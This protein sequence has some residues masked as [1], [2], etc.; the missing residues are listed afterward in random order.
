MTG[1]PIDP[2]HGAAMRIWHQSFTDLER[3][4]GYAGMLAERGRHVCSAGTVVDLHGV[5]PDTYPDGVAPVDVGGYRW[6]TEMIALQVVENCVRAEREGYDAV[7]ISCF[8]DPGLELARSLVDIP[9]VSSLETSLLMSCTI[10]RRPGLLT[11]DGAMVR[12]VERLVADY[13]FQGRLAGIDHLD[14]PLT[15]FDL[16]AGFGGSAALTER[17]RA[18]A[19]RLIARGAD[20]LIPAEGVLNTLMVRNAL[21]EVDGVPVLDSYGALLAMA[22]TLVRLKRRAGLRVSRSGAYAKPPAATADHVR[23][24]TVRALQRDG[25]R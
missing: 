19:R 16:D 3:L 2:Q 10:G 12:L 20:V 23:T 5:R 18:N 24:V 1:M 11:L 13:G 17:F 15:E 4:P 8:A 7:A 21:E 25:A 6:V 22:E 9:V 14:P